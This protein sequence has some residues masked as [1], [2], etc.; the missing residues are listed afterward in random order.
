MPV[1]TPPLKDVNREEVI[2]NFEEE[3]LKFQDDLFPSFL[4]SGLAYKNINLK[5]EKDWGY[6]GDIYKGFTYP[7]KWVTCPFNTCG[8]GSDVIIKT[9]EEHLG[10]H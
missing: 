9:L 2:K 1:D 10:I 3:I 5:K 7:K 4:K 8:C 6:L